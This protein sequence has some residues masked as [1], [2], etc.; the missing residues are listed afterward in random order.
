M[1]H[2]TS[3]KRWPPLVTIS[4]YFTWSESERLEAA[5]LSECLRCF[6]VDFWF[7]EKKADALIA[8]TTHADSPNRLASHALVH[9]PLKSDH[10][11]H[12]AALAFVPVTLF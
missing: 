6:V 9:G 10:I 4:F 11:L 1:Q 7:L 2:S 5:K 8:F 3:R 12:I